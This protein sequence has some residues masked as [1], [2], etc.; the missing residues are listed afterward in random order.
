MNYLLFELFPKNINYPKHLDAKPF[1]FFEILSHLR[2]NQL[3]VHVY[4]T[5]VSLFKGSL[6]PF[7]LFENSNKF[8]AR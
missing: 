3:V 1:Q 6:S 8:C 7:F 5:V 4:E 2:T